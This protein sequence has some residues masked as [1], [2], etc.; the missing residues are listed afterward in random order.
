MDE[1]D[2]STKTAPGKGPATETDP[3][4]IPG[5]N[6]SSEG[7]AEGAGDSTGGTPLSVAV[8]ALEGL[9]EAVQQLGSVSEDEA[10]AQVGELAAGLRRVSDSLAQAAGGTPAE[11]PGETETETPEPAAQDGRAVSEVI[12]AVRATLGRVDALVATAARP[13]ETAKAAGDSDGGG[14]DEEEDDADS[15]GEKPAAGTGDK[16]LDVAA[17]ACHLA[18]LVE[19]LKS[20]S[21]TVQ[22]QNQRLSRLEKRSGLPNSTPVGEG[23]RK[24]QDE[25]PGW[26]MDLNRPFDRQ[27]VDKAV[28]FHDL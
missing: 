15:D 8:A 19:G 11:G 28:S 17:I 25:D 4:G 13:V 24:T 27:S 23:A 6:T 10:R 18:A 1:V 9:T 2:S 21:E 5:D 12:A 22:K 20:L 14:A 16:P 7:G 26:P 3:A